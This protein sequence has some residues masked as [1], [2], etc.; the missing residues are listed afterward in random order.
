MSKLAALHEPD[1]ISG[2]KDIVTKLGDRS[3][4][5]SI[6]TQWKTR[7]DSLDEAA[8]KALKEG[9]GDS[10]MLAKLNICK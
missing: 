1:L 4:N 9:L 7:I 10:K 3:V 2:G 5:S 6:G 8:S